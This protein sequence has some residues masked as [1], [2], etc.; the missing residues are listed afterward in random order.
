MVIGVDMKMVRQRAFAVGGIRRV[1]MSMRMSM[2]AISSMSMSRMAVADIA[3]VGMTGMT[4]TDVPDM[5][6][7]VAHVRIAEPGKMERV[8]DVAGVA[9]RMRKPAHQQRE[10]AVHAAQHQAGQIDDI[11]WVQRIAS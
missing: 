3:S 8:A 2:A 10:Q 7:R 11:Q 9:G 4:M 5:S 6:G 1:T